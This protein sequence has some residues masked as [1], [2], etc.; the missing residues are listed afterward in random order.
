MWSKVRKVVATDS[1]KAKLLTRFMILLAISTLCYIKPNRSISYLGWARLGWLHIINGFHLAFC[2]LW[3]GR[4][5]HNYLRCQSGDKCKL[6]VILSITFI[7]SN[8][9]LYRKFS[10]YFSFQVNY[11][12]CVS[13]SLWAIKKAFNQSPRVGSVYLDISTI[14]KCAEAVWEMTA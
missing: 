8:C 3:V 2:C 9:V 5:S 13:K 1:V 10:R 6:S 14:S 11:W 7:D 12:M 4:Y